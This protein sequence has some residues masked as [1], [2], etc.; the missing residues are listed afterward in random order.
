MTTLLIVNF[1]Y[2][3][4]QVVATQGLKSHL[5]FPFLQS[6]LLV[7]YS[8]EPLDT[9]WRSILKRVTSFFRRRTDVDEMEK[10]EV[11]LLVRRNGAP[12]AIQNI[13]GHNRL[14]FDFI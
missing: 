2:Y 4:F 5:L 12:Q 11:G 10:K 14:S 6:T 7:H 1:L 9:C 8:D 13:S 3:W